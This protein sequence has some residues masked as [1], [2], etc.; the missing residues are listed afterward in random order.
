VCVCGAERSTASR[1]F[2]VDSPVRMRFFLSVFSRQ[3]D[4]NKDEKA[5]NSCVSEKKIGERQGC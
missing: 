2:L 4:L 1:F 5:S 3:E